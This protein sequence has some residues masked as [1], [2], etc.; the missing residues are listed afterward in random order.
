MSK[1]S[2]DNKG[3]QRCSQV[4]KKCSSKRLRRIKFCEKDVW[5]CVFVAR[6]VGDHENG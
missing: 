1:I 2:K 3:K 6:C 4:I 5:F